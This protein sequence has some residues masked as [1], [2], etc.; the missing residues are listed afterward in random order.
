MKLPMLSAIKRRVLGL[1]VLLF[2]NSAYSQVIEGALP[3]YN[4][5]IPNSKP[6]PKSYKEI[7]EN[8]RVR[9]V[10]QPTL[11]PFFPEKGK[12]NG[13]AIIICPGGGYGM[14]AYDHEGMAVAKRFAESGITA[15]VLKYRL[16]SDEIMKDRAIGPLQDA[17]RALQLVRE[18][19]ATWHVD[20]NKVG[21][22]GF[23]AGGHLAATATTHFYNPVIDVKK[24]QS[25]RP[26]FAMLIYPVI[27]MGQYTHG[28]SKEN[29]IGK[30]ASAEMVKLYSNELQVKADTPPV[31]LVHAEDDGAVPPQNSMQFYNAMIDNKVK[32]E[33]NMYQAGG[34]GFGM[35]NK[36]TTDEWFIR[37]LNW[38][39]E[40]KFL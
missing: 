24:G 31:F 13:T 19:A 6:T 26:D 18:N 3:L 39:R 35:V 5:P 8:W 17:Q 25:V 10:S 30:N 7:I 27:S 38:L 36:T 14:L 2:M 22:M 21:I 16:P 12:E 29:L 20:P 33:L 1:F 4:G 37:G 28:G 15:F 11:Q 34:H 32:G 40:N 23:S 9:F